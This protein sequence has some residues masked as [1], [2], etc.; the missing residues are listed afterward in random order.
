MPL[1]GR[2]RAFRR[3]LNKASEEMLAGEVAVGALEER[4]GDHP[5]LAKRLGE[6]Y[7]STDAYLERIRQA[8]TGKAEER[9]RKAADGFQEEF[10]GMLES[11]YR[12]TSEGTAPAPGSR[13]ASYDEQT[14]ALLAALDK[15]QDPEA[16]RHIAL[17]IER[18]RR[19][20]AMDLDVV[21]ASGLPSPFTGK[22]DAGIISL[23]PE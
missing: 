4:L 8:R 9:V 1:D 7:G 14:R 20:R 18:V 2:V 6:S 15:T 11:A 23:I 13:L 5:A 10:N 12:G 3:E 22:N 19:G 21:D 16:R 17:A